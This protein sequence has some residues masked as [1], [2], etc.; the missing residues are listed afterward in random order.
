MTSKRQYDVSAR[1]F[2]TPILSWS[3]IGTVLQNAGKKTLIIYD[4]KQ[5]GVRAFPLKRNS[6]HA[7]RVA[8]VFLCSKIS[9]YIHATKTGI[10]PS[11]AET[12]RKKKGKRKR[13]EKTKKSMLMTKNNQMYNSNKISLRSKS[14]RNTQK[15]QKEIEL[16]E[17][18][19]ELCSTKQH[20]IYERPNSLRVYKMA[21]LYSFSPKFQPKFA[22]SNRIP[23][24]LFP[25]HLPP[26]LQ[27]IRPINT[28]Q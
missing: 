26:K 7:F 23:L 16:Y 3:K 20:C 17:E 11:K 22:Q 10:N 1:S 25:N 9:E 5:I 8:A 28:E 24:K 15:Y 12:C 13:K 4:I 18:N 21:T 2:T 19:S 27:A 6:T 14:E